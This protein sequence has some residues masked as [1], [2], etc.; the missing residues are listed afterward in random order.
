MQK[1]N[2]RDDIIRTFRR[3]ARIGFN[4]HNYN[5]IQTYKRIEM[6]CTSQRSKLD[7]LA[8]FD[9]LRLLRL[10]GEDEALLCV[11]RVYFS[12]PT[13]RLSRQEMARQIKKCSLELFCDERTVYRR[14]EAAREL[15][16]QVR[17]SIGLI[18]D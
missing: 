7:M 5:P 18:D 16:A 17:S 12:N 11:D 15:Y 6:F 1:K 2:D 9:T 13:Q 8:V 4:D 3:F 10:S 14:L